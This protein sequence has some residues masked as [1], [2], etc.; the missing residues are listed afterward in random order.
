MVSAEGEEPGSRGECTQVVS[1]H[2]QVAVSASSYMWFGQHPSVNTGVISIEFN[3]LTTSTQQWKET[4]LKTVAI[5]FYVCVDC[6]HGYNT[7]LREPVTGECSCGMR[8]RG[9]GERE[10]AE[11]R[12]RE[13]GREK[14]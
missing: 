6:T 7:A 13:Q 12:K 14:E 9:R 2:A 4:M 8:E 5:S 10:N 1:K 11:E 3:C